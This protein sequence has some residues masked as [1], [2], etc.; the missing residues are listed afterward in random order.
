MQ[1]LTKQELFK[2]IKCSNKKDIEDFEQFEKRYI[3]SKGRYQINEIPDYWVY[4]PKNHKTK[5]GYNMAMYKINKE[6]F[7]YLDPESRST[8]N[9]L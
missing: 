3:G 4:W 2:I 8:M 7:Y 1:L 9:K 5:W 6:T